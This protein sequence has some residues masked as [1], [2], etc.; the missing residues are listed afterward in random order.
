MSNASELLQ[1]I[2]TLVQSQ[3]F[4]AAALDGIQAI[5]KRLETTLAD[6]AVAQQLAKDR[7]DKCNALTIEVGSLNARIVHLEAEATK[8]RDTAVKGQ[9]AIYTAQRYESVA[10]AWKEAMQTVFK[11][12][13]MREVVMHNQSVM[14]PGQNG[15]S[16]YPQSL[17]HQENITRTQE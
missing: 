13:T 17:Q 16:P 11:P 9:E 5:K 15:C 12:H 10:A 3:T 1:Q 8:M 2:E 4:T 6:L 7:L 14:V